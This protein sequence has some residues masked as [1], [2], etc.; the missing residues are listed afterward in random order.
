MSPPENF[1]PSESNRSSAGG[2][3]DDDNHYYEEYHSPREGK[4]GEDNEVFGPQVAPF[5]TSTDH[6]PVM[7]TS[8]NKQTH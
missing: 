2:G 4:D 8:P 1:S 3:G 5:E 7:T 6:I